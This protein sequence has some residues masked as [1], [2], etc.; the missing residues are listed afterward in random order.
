MADLFTILLI[1]DN[2]DDEHLSVR[3]LRKAGPNV[4][5]E[6]ARDGEQALCRLMDT[7]ELL[8]DIVLLD[9]KLPKIGG[10]ELLKKLRSTPR[11]AGLKII[12]LS[13]LD[14]PEELRATH[15]QFADGYMHKPISTQ[16]F[17]A[18][19]NRIAVLNSRAAVL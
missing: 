1:E 18:E 7:R 10:L 6:V 13:A 3:Q 15:Q 12:V 4:G 19:A 9:L 17:V 8:P 14:E 2:M 5:I 11:T 16:D